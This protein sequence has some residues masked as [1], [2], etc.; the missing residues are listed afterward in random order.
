MVRG[1]CADK[2]SKTTTITYMY[3]SEVL[4]NVWKIFLYIVRFGDELIYILNRRDFTF[5]DRHS[6]KIEEKQYTDAKTSET[7]KRNTEVDKVR[8]V[9]FYVLSHFYNCSKEQTILR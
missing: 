5:I 2:M 9:T 3:K 7:F 8:R 6:C 4:I 1:S